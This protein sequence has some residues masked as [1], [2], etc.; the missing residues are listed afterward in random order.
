MIKDASTIHSFCTSRDYERKLG[1]YVHFFLLS[2]LSNL[3]SGVINLN[4]CNKQRRIMG[5]A[6]WYPDIDRNHSITVWNGLMRKF[7]S[8]GSERE[9]KA[10]SCCLWL[11]LTSW[12]LNNTRSDVCKSKYFVTR[13]QWYDLLTNF[14]ILWFYFYTTREDCSRKHRKENLKLKFETVWKGIK[15]VRVFTLFLLTYFSIGVRYFSSLS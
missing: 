13:V 6:W 8:V 3:N 9:W 1:E 2:I 4:E 15:Y 7:L 10:I 14:G 5:S 12:S 11:E